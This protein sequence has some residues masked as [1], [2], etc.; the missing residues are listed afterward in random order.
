MG[1]LRSPSTSKTKQISSGT[2]GQR[3]RTCSPSI[4][5][6]EG[7]MSSD[8]PKIELAANET[9]KRPRYDEDVNDE[10]A[11]S[12]SR[13]LASD[14]DQIEPNP[15][16]DGDIDTLSKQSGQE[17]ME[18]LCKRE[19]YGQTISSG[20]SMLVEVKAG[21]LR[22]IG[23]LLC[24]H[25]SG[26]HQISPETF[27]SALIDATK[28]GYDQ[29]AKQIIDDVETID[30]DFQIGNQT[31]LMTA[32]EF[33]RSNTVRLLLGAGADPIK[34]N[35]QGE[36][37][38]TFALSHGKIECAQILLEEHKP[39]EADLKKIASLVVSKNQLASL[40]LLA[41]FY[42]VDKFSQDLLETGVL[43]GNTKTVQYL[44][45]HGADI[46]A[47]CSGAPTANQLLWGG[48]VCVD[49]KNIQHVLRHREDSNTPCAGNT[50]A[51]LAA[52][53][54]N[55]IWKDKSNQIDMVKFLVRNGACVNKTSSFESPLIVAVERVRD[56]DV[57]QCLL[58]HG[59]DVNAEGNEGITPLAATLCQT[60]L[61]RIM[62]S[63]TL[64]VLLDAGAD[65]RKAYS[66][67]GSVLHMACH[68]TP[69]TV[70]LLV[71]AGA[72]LEAL[73]DGLTPLLLASVLSPPEVVAQLKDC[74]AN[75]RAVDKDGKSALMRLLQS[76][77]PPEEDTIRMLASDKELV[78][79]KAPDGRTP[80]F[81]AL[82][83]GMPFN[84]RAV[85]ILLEAGANPHVTHSL[86][87]EERTVLSIMLD[88]KN[89]GWIHFLSEA[90]TLCLKEL[91]RHGALSSLPK[92]KCFPLLDMMTS[93]MVQ[94]LV[95]NGM[96]PFC[97]DSSLMNVPQS[98]SESD[99]SDGRD[100]L[101]GCLSPFA[102]SLLQ[103]NVSVARYMVGNCF[104]TRVDVVG[105][106]KLRDLRSWFERTSQCPRSLVFL[107][108]YM[109]Q[110]MSLLQLSFVTVSDQLGEMIGREDRVR[111]T[112]LPNFLQEK[113]LFKTEDFPMDF[114]TP[115]FSDRSHYSDE[116]SSDSSESD[117]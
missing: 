27:S 61:H 7:A 24:Q 29:V 13:V 50:T 57:L 73:H 90:P 69:E 79:M 17:A 101:T 72:D 3:K 80:L 44:L 77:R 6:D 33:G 9:S 94:L 98:D 76:G 23:S 42:H 86:D 31:A 96:V 10:N 93:D 30:L 25:Q 2:Q 26:E 55:N 78:N 81:I 19:L 59:A 32:A 67:S 37:A 87:D 38:L 89:F 52:L 21:V 35:R 70:K 5:P 104:L 43:S 75:M 53:S 8:S 110:P 114:I 105:S 116:S 66:Y 46:N 113:L 63:D 11:D 84:V 34:K 107:T 1:N 47:P 62:Y 111:K 106:T 65:P 95:T 16:A 112:G 51:L 58:E 92:T 15:D 39:C 117:D 68:H 40:Q 109:S 83:G 82:F 54:I 115:D 22:T 20:Q 60:G 18:D 56:P 4:A 41:S 12:V 71:N 102:A 103:Q 49:I 85:K 91:I 100:T 99:F 97:M 64:K 28:S 88:Y 108:E 14:T 48:K 74:G 45:E 36:T